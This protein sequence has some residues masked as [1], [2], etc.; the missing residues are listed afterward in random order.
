MNALVSVASIGTAAAVAEASGI[1]ALPEDPVFAAIERVGLANAKLNAIVADD[2]EPD[3]AVHSSSIQADEAVEALANTIATTPVGL[4]ALTTFLRD[5]RGNLNATVASYLFEERPAQDLAA[6]IDTAVRGMSGLKPWAG[7]ELAQ[8]TELDDPIFAAIERHRAAKVAWHAQYKEFSLAEERLSKAGYLGQ[9][10]IPVPINITPDIDL[11][12]PAVVE[13]LK[14]RKCYTFKA[15]DEACAT[16]SFPPEKLAAARNFAVKDLRSQIAKYAHARKRSGLTQAKAV[17]ARASHHEREMLQELAATIPTTVAGINALVGYWLEH[18][19]DYY[20]NCVPE[21]LG[22]TLQLLASI[23][24]ASGRIAEAA[25][26]RLAA[27]RKG[28][29]R[30]ASA[31]A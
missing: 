4:A 19:R 9:P 15:I 29:N 23:T 22:D 8:L 5:A 1:A 17:N 27:E 3:S 18:H 13:N 6:S 7:K 11:N 14:I 25:P 10:W 21:E 24:A 30:L 2:D 31:A 20:L 16:N 28:R 12:N 26:G